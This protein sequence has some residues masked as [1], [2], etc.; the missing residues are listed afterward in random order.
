MCL[1]GLLRFQ[2]RSTVPLGCV[3]VSPVHVPRRCF[4]VPRQ[5]QGFGSR[6]VFHWSKETL[7]KRERERKG[8]RLHETP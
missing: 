5:A 6:L 3:G 2:K 8:F 1:L 7:Q 4:S